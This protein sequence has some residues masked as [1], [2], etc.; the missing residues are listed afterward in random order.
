MEIYVLNSSFEQIAIIDTF[1]SLLWVTRYFEPGDFELYVPADN[2]LL[3]VLKFGYYLTREDDDTVMLIEKIEIQTDAEN[4]NFFIVSGRSLESIL[5][6][7]I[8]WEQTNVNAKACKATFTL[9]Q[10]NVI[11]PSVSDRKISNFTIDTSSEDLV[12]S[13]LTQQFTGNGLLETIVNIAKQFGFGWRIKLVDK[14]FVYSC[15]LRD[16]VDVTFSPEFD[17]LINSNYQCDQKA[18]KTI[19]LIAG[20]GEGIARKTATYGTGS[21]LARRELYVDARDISSNEGE[22]QAA[23]YTELLQSRGKEKLSENVI[24]QNFDGNIEPST[25]YVY[26]KDY[27]VGNIVSIENEYGIVAKPR[28]VEIIESWDDNGYSVVPTFEKWEV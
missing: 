21:G 8:V 4:G 10:K 25:T 5:D 24:S 18:L 13:V 6:R 1:K 22:I 11:E 9:L 19:A 12:D 16:E 17:N 26:R 27:D 20:E 14:K 2:Q 15:Y 7:R 28:I 3:D 23:E